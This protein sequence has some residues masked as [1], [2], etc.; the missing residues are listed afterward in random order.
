METAELVVAI[1]LVVI[2]VSRLAAPA[3]VPAPVALLVVGAVLSALPGMPEVRLSPEVA[4]YGLLPPLLYSA[5]ITSSLVDFRAYRSKILS[6]SVGLVLF[7]A[8]GVGLVT[9]WLLPVPFAVAFALGAVV[10]PPDAVAATAVARRIGLP[11]KI[12]TVLEGESLLNDATALVSLRTALAA[13]GLAAHG[14]DGLLAQV[15]PATVA[16]DLLLAAL[17]GV[18]VGVVAHLVVGWLRRRLTEV[19][20]DTALSFIAPFLAYAPAEAVGASGVLAVVTAGLLLAHRAPVLQSAPS[21]LAERT[22]WSSVTFVLENAVFLLIGLQVSGLVTD[23]RAG[24]LGTGRTVLVAAAVLLTVLVLRPLWLFGQ[25]VVQVLRGT[26]ERRAVLR[27][28]LLSG[29]AGMRGVVTL[30]AAL[31]LPE[32]TPLRPELVLVALVV[33]VGTLL[34]QGTTLPALARLLGVQGPDPRED[35]LQ[36][37]TV[38]GATTGAGLRMLQDDPGADPAVVEVIRQQAADRV[39]RSWERLGTLGPGDRES[40]AE[41]RARLRIEMIREERRELL[42]IRSQGRVDHAVLTGVLGQLDAEETALVSSATQTADVRDSELRP[43]ARVAGACEHLADDAAPHPPSETDGCPECRAEGLT[44]VHLRSCTACGHVGCCDS[45]LGRHA[46]RHFERTGHP[47]MR[48]IEPGEA[49]RWC[50]VDQV[51]G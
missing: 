41:A 14:T 47:V 40:P 8:A 4:L 48:S 25:G 20:A 10:A 9:W 35:A 23:T 27:W 37:A 38:L 45:S 21:R 34:L 12:T 6:L 51:L 39:N 19:P 5:A 43:P 30:A 7:T 11:R 13:A 26:S 50:F 3:R 16:L 36:E 31:T 29:W 28:S 24:E 2:I 33:T 17:G 32:E 22:N 44:W 15:T 18:A 1:V 49:W 46:S 42:R